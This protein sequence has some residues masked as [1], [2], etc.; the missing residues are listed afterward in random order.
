MTEENSSSTKRWNGV[1][2]GTIDEVSSHVCLDLPSARP[3]KRSFHLVLEPDDGRAL[4]PIPERVLA[5]DVDTV[6]VDSLKALDPN[7][8]IR[9][10]DNLRCGNE[11]RY[12]ITSSACA[13]L[14]VTRTLSPA[15]MGR[16][17]LAAGRS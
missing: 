11:R 14:T 15:M 12:S 8:P 1:P 2:R 3:P 16:L 13:L 5:S 17:A 4:V 9:E 10:A 6:A 7:R